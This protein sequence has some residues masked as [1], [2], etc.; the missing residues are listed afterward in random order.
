[1]R[2]GNM[3]VCRFRFTEI[4]L[5]DCWEDST[6]STHSRWSGSFMEGEMKKIPLRGKYGR[7]RFTLVDEDDFRKHSKFKW[8]LCIT[9]CAVRSENYKQ[10]KDSGRKRQ[11]IYLHR[12][13]NKTPPGF[14]TDHIN[15]DR[16]DNRKANLRT[17]T[18]S[19]NIMN[20]GLPR[21][22]TSGF[23]CVHTP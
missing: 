16:L 12:E 1:M 13:I 7:G 2:F 6:G 10:A 15:H 21:T 20:Q 11:R 17:A 14:H 9:G 23:K 3:P 5:L 19:Q 8:F 22:N 4:N 18:V